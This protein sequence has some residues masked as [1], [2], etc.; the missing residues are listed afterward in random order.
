MSVLD[1]DPVRNGARATRATAEP[2]DLHARLHEV[3]MRLCRAPGTILFV[4]AS[5][6]A[7]KDSYVYTVFEQICA[8]TGQPHRFRRAAMGGTG[9]LIGAWLL[10]QESDYDL[11]FFEYLTGDMNFGLIPSKEVSELIPSVAATV[12][13]ANAAIVFINLFRSDRSFDRDAP[14][15]KEYSD[16]F[17]VHGIPYINAFRHFLASDA[18]E[19]AEVYRDIVHTTPAGSVLLG[20][21]VADELL[22]RWLRSRVAADGRL[23]LRHT[24]KYENIEFIPVDAAKVAE[25]IPDA[26]SGSIKSEA[27]GQHFDYSNINH[28]VFVNVVIKGSLFALLVKA[29]PTSGI[30]EVEAFARDTSE[31]KKSFSTV[32]DEHCYYDRV[33]TA[34]IFKDGSEFESVRLRLTRAKIDPARVKRFPE[35]ILDPG[36]EF[37]IIGFL[38][39]EIQPMYTSSSPVHAAVK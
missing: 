17:G 15:M 10:Q 20:R 11:V 27:S 33:K 30:V 7:Q 5:V 26:S 22:E 35:R 16:A 32:F 29:G 1:H 31:V 18:A 34:P 24:Y 25:L 12:T 8:A 4:G 21:L 14:M 38:G 36:T 13:Q 19:L 2:V 39:K 6:T 3:L 28:D 37:S 23:D 9:S